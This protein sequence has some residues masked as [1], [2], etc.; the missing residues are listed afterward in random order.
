MGELEQSHSPPD[1]PQQKEKGLEI[2]FSNESA[3]AVFRNLELNAENP[4]SPEVRLTV[5]KRPITIKEGKS[6]GTY[7]V[8]IDNESERMRALTQKAE[9]LLELPEKERL[10][11]VL[12]I[13]RGNVHYAYNDV[14]G[15][16][17]E[18]NPELAKWVAEN[19]SLNAS[20]VTNV[21]L[22]EIIE[23]RYGV[24]RHL[25][26]AYLW[27]AQKAGLKGIILNSD[28]GV[29]K[30]I[31]RSDT[32]EKL[33]KS[34]DIGKSAPAHSWVEIKTSD[35]QWIPVDP[36]TKLVGDSEERLTMFK[37]ANYMAY[38]NLGL[39][40][41]SEPGGEL[42]TKGKSIIFAPAEAKASGTYSLELKST[43]PT[44]IIRGENLPPTNFPFSGEGRLNINT[45]EQFGSMALDIVDVKEEKTFPV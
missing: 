41:E 27:L 17:S 40:I 34:V 26:V 39:D 3:S 36:S 33:F 35:G 23:K 25:A 42:S 20:S 29:I 4:T 19:T 7:A 43:K 6:Y 13:L 21:P 11:K 8:L 18:T 37:E 38:G 28:L 30:N 2:S 44:I 10:A 32:K 16:L 45:T 9:T 24:C 22:S 12:D 31:Q 15:K 5:E 14:V 1:K